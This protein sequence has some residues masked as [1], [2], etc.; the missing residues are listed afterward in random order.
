[1]SYILRSAGYAPGGSPS[2]PLS[3]PPSWRGFA[4]S[5]APG[6]STATTWWQPGD[7]FALDFVNGRY[8]RGGTAASL[9]SVLSVSR[10]SDALF[11]DTAGVW[12]L[13]GPNIPAITDRGL[14]IGG[15]F[16][17]KISAYNF[18]PAALTLRNAAA[19]IAAAVPGTTAGHGGGGSLGLFGITAD[20]EKVAAAGFG[21]VA[22]GNVFQVDM[23][24]DTAGSG[25]FNF[26]DAVGNTNP[27]SWGAWVRNDSVDATL[28]VVGSASYGTVTLAPGPEYSFVKVENW[29]P[30]ATAKFRPQIGVGGV[31]RLF[32]MQVVQ[33][34]F[35]PPPI[36]TE[37]ASAT[38][39]ADRATVP[40][41]P[42]TAAALELDGGFEFKLVVNVERLAA[43]S[44][45]HLFALGSGSGDV[46]DL[47]LNTSNVL[48]L[49]RAKTGQPTADRTKTLTAA[50]IYEIAGR[51]LPDEVAMTVNGE[52]SGSAAYG[53]GF[54]AFDVFNIGQ[55]ISGSNFLNGPLRELRLREVAA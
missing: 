52:D 48:T 22:N 50:G 26:S 21:G 6:F 41:F 23:T 45:R 27:H 42:A 38:R 44:T 47:F 5:P 4:G 51:V 46:V 31:L 15:Q 12:S 40:D 11:D 2:W 55:N 14:Y 8:M 39:L 54:P 7:V 32:G 25:F 18:N 17:N 1:M 30:D 43:P 16:T 33:S 29:T 35:L 20:A 34:A 53:Y 24:G 9:A 10:N 49:R 3:Q 36:V 19:F 28:R 13:F 37:G